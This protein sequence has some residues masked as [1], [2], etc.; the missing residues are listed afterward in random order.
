MEIVVH[1]DRN[2]SILSGDEE[3]FVGFLPFCSSFSFFRRFKVSS[4]FV[5]FLKVFYV[6]GI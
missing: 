4:E 5:T 3:K 1:W 2:I 6:G